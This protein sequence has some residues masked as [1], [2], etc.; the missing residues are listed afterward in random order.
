MPEQ[1]RLVARQ[2]ALRV[3]AAVMRAVRDYFAGQGFLE[4]ETPARVRSPG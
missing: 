1:A 3:R 2:P 4:V